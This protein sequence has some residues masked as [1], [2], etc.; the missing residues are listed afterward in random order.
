VSDLIPQR[1]GQALMTSP[2]HIFSITTYNNDKI[3]TKRSNT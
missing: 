3:R 2:I 1:G